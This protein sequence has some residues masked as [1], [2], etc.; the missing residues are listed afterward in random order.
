MMIP[1]KIMNN[2]FFLCILVKVKYFYQNFQVTK[3]NL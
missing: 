2:D 3:G 1:S